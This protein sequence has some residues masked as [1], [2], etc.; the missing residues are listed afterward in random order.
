MSKRDNPL[1]IDV[2]RE[3]K[4]DI[5]TAC[6]INKKEVTIDKKVR[7]IEK[8]PCSKTIEGKCTAFWDP[9]AKWKNG[10]C[11]MAT[12]IIYKEDEVNFK[13]NPIKASKKGTG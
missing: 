8:G 10:D 4:K 1:N 5:I 6:L 3:T 9:A 2:M 13:L 11:P 12:H 7:M